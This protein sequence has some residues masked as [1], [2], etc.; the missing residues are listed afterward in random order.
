MCIT[1]RALTHDATGRSCSVGLKSSFR[2]AVR[3]ARL[4]SGI[5][6]A[7]ALRSDNAPLGQMEEAPEAVVSPAPHT[8]TASLPCLIDHD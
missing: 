1:R 7:A 2:A 3:E 4:A 8:Y 6:D 5:T